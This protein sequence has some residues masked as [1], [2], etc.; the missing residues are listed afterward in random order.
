L[1]LSLVADGDVRT[2]VEQMGLAPDEKKTLLV[3][4]SA[5]APAAPAADAATKLGESVSQ[6]APQEPARLRLAWITLWDTDAEDGDAVRIDSAGF[7][8]T[9]TLSKQPVTIAIPV[10]P[11][12]IVEVTGVRDGEGG[13]ITVGLASGGARAVFPIMSVGQTLGL[14]VQVNQ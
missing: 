2:A 6:P 9:L 11:D 10:P 7:S 13:G 1:G 8:R 4:L 12:S 5:P 3:N 14:R